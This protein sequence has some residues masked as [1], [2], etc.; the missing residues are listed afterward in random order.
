MIE[1]TAEYVQISLPV[2][3]ALLAFASKDDTR[4]HLGIG[5]DGAYLC[6][7]DGHRGVQ[8]PLTGAVSIH[9]GKVWSHAHV[10]TLLKVAKARKQP[11]IALAF[12]D[13]LAGQKFPPF[14]QVIPDYGMEATKPVGFNPTYFADLGKV[15]KACGVVGAKMTSARDPRDPV[16]FTIGDKGLTA[17]AVVMPM[18]I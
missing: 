14:A 6:A 3:A 10:E 17:R 7:T 8:F 11:A 1:V 13:C 9:H 18:N 16:L 2:A 4:P 5:I 15:C 12:A